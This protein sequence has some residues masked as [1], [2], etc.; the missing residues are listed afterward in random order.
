MVQFLS[1]SPVAVEQ[2]LNSISLGLIL[3]DAEQ[4]VCMWNGWIERHSGVVA[5]QALGRHISEV[6]EELPSRAILNAISNTLNY[7]LPVVLSNALH[8]SP[9]PLFERVEHDE[10]KKR[11]HQSITIT[12]L[13]ADDGSRLCLIQ[14]SD[15]STSIKREKIL[16]THSEALKREATTDSL[17]G[18]YNRRFFDEHFKIAMGHAVRHNVPLS[19]FMLDIDFFKEYNDS[20]GHVA[21]DKALIQVATAL[22]K[23]LLRATDVLARFGGE[24]FILILPNMVPELAMQFA[25]KLRCAVWDLN[26]PHINSRVG[27]RVSISI[28]FSNYHKHPDIDQ[29]LLLKCADAAL[30]QAKKTG[31]NQSYYLPLQ[32]FQVSSASTMEPSDS[33]DEG[34][35][36]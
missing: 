7:G 28:G 4:H 17:T 29:H 27:D 19:I 13:H 32:D 15:S 30:Y 2:I 24:E 21:G 31:R 25:E 18:I 35:L 14:V 10:E 1:T 33:H 8:R 6:F 11:I 26:I 12:P 3:V 20:Y 5:E 23:Q 36:N 34:L 9:L 22:R 16:R